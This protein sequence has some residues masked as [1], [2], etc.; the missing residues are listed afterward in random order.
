MASSSSQPYADVVSSATTMAA[1]MEIEQANGEAGILGVQL[2]MGSIAEKV[3]NSQIG[4]TGA[5]FIITDKGYRQFTQDTE[6]AGLDVSQ[7]P[8]S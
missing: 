8:F 4:K 3:D 5:P 1:T 6:L 7:K 2:D